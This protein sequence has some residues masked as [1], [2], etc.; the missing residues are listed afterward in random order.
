MLA[1]TSRTPSL[2]ALL[3]LW[4]PARRLILKLLPLLRSLVILSVDHVA[5]DFL[6]RSNRPV[7]QARRH[8]RQWHTAGQQVR[9][10]RMAATSG[11]LRPSGRLNGRNSSDGSRTRLE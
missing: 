11:G 3:L 7:A 8:R 10:V 5:I 2:H 1:A 4:L 9:R 6:C